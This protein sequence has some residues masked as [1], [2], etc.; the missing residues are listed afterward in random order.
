VTTSHEFAEHLLTTYLLERSGGC[1][2]RT[3][4]VDLPGEVPELLTEAI[5]EHLAAIYDGGR[6]A[7]AAVVVQASRHGLDRDDLLR[8]A[9]N[10]LAERD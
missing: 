5:R 6:Q 3:F 2:S 8:E 4:E 10:L 1:D 9:L 7:L